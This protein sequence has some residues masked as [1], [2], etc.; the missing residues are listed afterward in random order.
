MVDKKTTR[1][2]ANCKGQLALTVR[3]EK[4]LRCFVH[5]QRSQTLAQ[6]ITQ[7]NDGASRRVSK[8]SVQRSLPRMGFGSC[9]CT[10]VPLL[11]ARHRVARLAWARELRDWSVDDS[12]RVAWR[13]ESPFRLL[14]ADG[15]LRIWRQAHKAMDPAY[16][17]VTV[18]G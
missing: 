7:L 6:F 11:K 14:N 13:A 2:L 15:R 4:W 10:R 9:R 12:K 1:D 8:R 18:Q 16:Q 17:V 5:S 3:G